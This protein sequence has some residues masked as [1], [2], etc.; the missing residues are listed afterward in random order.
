MSVHDSSDIE[1]VSNLDP[2]EH[3]SDDSAVDSAS[4]GEHS[5]IDPGTSDHVDSSPESNSRSSD[6]DSEPNGG[7]SSDSKGNNDSDEGIFG[8]MF[9]ARKTDKPTTKKQ[10]SWPQSSSRSW[11]CKTEL[12]KQA[13]TPSLE[14]DPHLDKPERKKKKPTTGRSE[15]PK[16]PSKTT[17]KAVDKIAQEVDTNY[18]SCRGQPSCQLIYRCYG[19]A[20]RG[21][22]H[23]DDR[24][25]VCMSGRRG[26]SAKDVR[27][28]R[29]AK[30]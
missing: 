3:H 21:V 14:N 26:N 10:E 24:I 18:S 20:E 11:S 17:P 2:Q 5:V 15:T 6:L 27:G 4:E 19:G 29:T 12:Q 9:S 1:M 22:R 7:L 8:D 25:P 28:S 16:A 13:H 23:D 30:P